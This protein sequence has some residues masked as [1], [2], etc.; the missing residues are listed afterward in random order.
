[1]HCIICRSEK[2]RRTGDGEHPIPLALG[3]SWT[4]DRVCI[5]C[6]NTFGMS[7]DA[8]L[9]KLT[10]IEER[11]IELK[12]EGHSGK[13][14]N[15][16]REA[17]RQPVQVTDD[18]HHRVKV[19]LKEDGSYDVFT[20]PNI[21]FEIIVNPDGSWAAALAPHRMVLDPRNRDSAEEMIA[22]RLQQALADRGIT[23]DPDEI[24][25][26]SA[27]LAASLTLVANQKAVS[28]PYTIRTGGHGPALLKIIYEAAWYWL[29]DPWLDDP[30]ARAMNASLRGDE[31]I[32]LQGRVRDGVDVRFDL[33]NLPQRE[34]HVIF[35]L[36]S[37]GKFIVE[38]QLFDLISGGF[39]ITEHSTAYKTPETDAIVM[40]APGGYFTEHKMSHPA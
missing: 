5:E 35:L 39:V 28:V 1:M 7:F 30:I 16:L 25:G 23:A 22:K 18:P 24:K 26:A 10:A 33:G 11:R 3:G 34:A 8:R 9:S 20:I 21:E 17:L 40:D 2:P 4:I 19:S 37:N 38:C 29:G 15:R 13:L 32:S 6:D 27:H 12:L 36:C 31:T 14:P